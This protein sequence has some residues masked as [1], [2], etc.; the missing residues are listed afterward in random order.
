MNWRR[1]LGGE[2]KTA[3]TS[4]VW[5]AFIPVLDN[6]T[7][8]VYP[9]AG[10]F[11]P[12]LPEI[13]NSRTF[14][15][16]PPPSCHLG[17]CKAGRRQQNRQSLAAAWDMDWDWLGEAT[18][19]QKLSATRCRMV[20]Q[21]WDVDLPSSQDKLV[22]AG[23]FIYPFLLMVTACYSRLQHVTVADSPSHCTSPLVPWIQKKGC[24]EMAPRREAPHRVLPE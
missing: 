14:N 16:P 15:R 8:W 2:T 1:S 24:S 21:C 3:S 18:H 13:F 5:L 7:T 4:T 11:H 19:P 20:I 9:G 10:G 22:F 17:S 12:F 23:M 6:P